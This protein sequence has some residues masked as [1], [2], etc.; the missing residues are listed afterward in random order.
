MID[1]EQG[2][3]C[4]Q[5]PVKDI[6]GLA[7]TTLENSAKAFCPADCDWSTPRLS[8]ASKRPFSRSHV[9]NA[10]CETLSDSG[11]S[12][13]AMVLHWPACGS[14]LV[15]HHKNLLNIEI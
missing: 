10:D 12:T 13:K 8:R 15:H 1:S 7:F 4:S 11:F 5:S 9:S 14:D 2:K 3:E 6:K